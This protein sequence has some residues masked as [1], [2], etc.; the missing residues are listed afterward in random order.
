VAYRPTRTYEVYEK[1]HWITNEFWGGY[2]RHNI[3]HRIEYNLDKEPIHDEYIS[4]NHAI[5][6]YEPFLSEG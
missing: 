6:M 2:V 3:I 4:E 5:M 1:E